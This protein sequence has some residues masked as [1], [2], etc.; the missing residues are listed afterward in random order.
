MLKLF[1]I[2]V[3]QAYKGGD[4]VLMSANK[5]YDIIFVDHF[6]PDMDGI[7][8]TKE[9][10]RMQSEGNK[11]IIIALTSNIT[12]QIKNRYRAAGVNDICMKPLELSELEAILMKWCSTVNRISLNQEVA[13]SKKEKEAI[14]AL[15]NSINEIDYAAGM[16]YAFDNP[17]LYMRILQVSLKDLKSC[18]KIIVN[19]YKNNSDKQLQMEIHKLKS[20]LY[21][22]GA[23]DLAEYAELVNNTIKQGGLKQIHYKYRIFIKR[24]NQFIPK[25]NSALN[26]YFIISSEIKDKQEIT[27]SSMTYEEYEQS[28]RNTIYYIRRYEYDSIKRELEDLIRRGLPEYRP[29]LEQAFKNIMNYDYEKALSEL[30]VIKNKTGGFPVLK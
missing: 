19:R 6:M 25:L 29:G 8:I 17:A 1:Y 10:R 2:N 15:V 28:L 16:K 3:D 21:D 9:I 26:T 5:D 13:D 27:C 7:Q 20:V 23:V 14:L 30:L 12:Q 11:S 22:I 4:A 24:I 18:I